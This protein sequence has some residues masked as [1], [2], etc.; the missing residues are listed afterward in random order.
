MAV[1]KK[2]TFELYLCE[3]PSQGRDIAKALGVRQRS[4]GYFQG[5][6]LFVSWCIGHLLEMIPPDGYDSRYKRWSLHDLPILPQEWKLEAKKSTRK[7]LTVIK[8]LLKQTHSVVI[9][10]DADREGETIAREVLEH[11]KFRGA[12]RRLWLSALDP[13]SIQRA[14]N[15]IRNSQETLPL[16]HSGLARGRADWLIG[17][18]LTRAYTILG[19]DRQVRSV[20]RVQTPTLALIVNRDRE[21]SHF[22]AQAYYEIAAFFQTKSQTSQHSTHSDNSALLETKWQFPTAIEQK[23]SLRHCFDKA[24]ALSVIE[25]CQNQYGVVTTATTQRKKQPPPL[26][27]NLS[28]LQQEASRRWGYGAQE[29]LNIAQSLYETHKLTT[30]PRSDCEYLPLSQLNDVSQIFQALCKNDPAICHLLA[31]ADQKQRSRVWN[32]KKITAHHAIIPTQ[33]A[34]AGGTG[35]LNNKERHIYDL[36]RRRYIA[37]FFPDYEYD[38]SIILITIH[39][40]QFKA[41]V[42]IPCVQGWKSV[43]GSTS[44]KSESG[45]SNKKKTL[46]KENEQVL[47]VVTK[48]EQLLCDHLDLQDK[49]T[50][51]PKHFTEGT[52]IKAMETIGSQVTDRVMKKIL[53]ETAGLGTQATRANIIQTLFQRQFIHKDKKL[54]KATPLG[55]ALCDAVPDT[56]KDPLLT[57]QWEQQLDDIANNNGQ[58]ING[59]LQQQINLLKTIITQIKQP[60]VKTGKGPASVQ[61][62]AGKPCPECGQPLEIRQAIRGSRVGQDYLGCSHFP[63]CRFYSWS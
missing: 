10:T 63:Q 56:I 54:I 48:G 32:D 52:L 53:R 44:A 38:Q 6:G 39:A 3:K 13:I 47:P 33:A 36:I 34:T 22:K 25:R 59:F 45:A 14:L 8:K 17:M 1:H 19:N 31:Q 55:F 28:G 4:D 12:T 15:S 24:L 50:T 29:V 60:E 9:A 51:P 37:Q 11:L 58:D 18:N 27:Y 7:Q 16:Y 62:K 20:G 5:D 41:S 43:L 2:N 40:D 21:I 61:Y 46:A 49:L 57:A 26:L 23:T 35:K 42:R 30:Y